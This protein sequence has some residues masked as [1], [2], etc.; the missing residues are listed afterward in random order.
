MGLPRF[1]SKAA[2]GLTQVLDGVTF[3]HLQERLSAVSVGLSIGPAAGANRRVQAL[4]ATNLLARLYPSLVLQARHSAGTQLAAE[5]AELA[6]AINPKVTL[7]ESFPR[8][9]S[10]CLAL[11]GEDACAQTTFSIDNDGWT[12][13]VAPGCSATS[14]S[15]QENAPAA[16][17]AACL[18]VAAIFLSVFSELGRALPVE[19]FSLSLFDYAQGS[20]IRAYPP[21]P[22]LTLPDTALVGAGAIG[23]SF[24]WVLSQSPATGSLDVVDGEQVDVS[25]LQRYVLARNRDPGKPKVF[26]AKRDLRMSGIQVRPFPL[27][28]DQYMSRYRPDARLEEAVAAVDN[29]ADRTAIQAVLPRRVWN[30]WTDLGDVGVSRHQFAGTEACLACLYA[31]STGG[32]SWMER[33]STGL[34]LTNQE[35]VDLLASGIGLNAS[36]IERIESHLH[37]RT[38]ALRRFAG[39]PLADFQHRAICGGIVA[40][41]GGAAATSPDTLVPLAHQS[42]LAGALLACEYLKGVGSM[43]PREQGNLVQLD[44]RTPFVPLWQYNRLKS[45][46]CICTDPDYQD[47]Y[48]G[49]YGMGDSRPARGRRARRQSL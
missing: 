11:G 1:F 10:L 18:G 32:P 27:P 44:I 16:S 2:L 39:T 42:A 3:E 9:G 24:L 43:R 41:L 6:R 38:G 25:N 40:R 8:E 7:L 23:N 15:L 46:R 47:R 21:L 14:P 4:L 28:F 12:V 31:Q 30:A 48:R 36:H 29:A 17:A 37:L 33:L 34:G 26:I 49:K 19:E 13:R 45:P 5:C 22:V 20:A 35:V